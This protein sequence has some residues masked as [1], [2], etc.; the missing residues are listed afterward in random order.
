MFFKNEKYLDGKD[1]LINAMKIVLQVSEFADDRD[2]QYKYVLDCDSPRCIVL[3]ENIDFLKKPTLPRKHNIELW[4]AGGKNI[5][6]LQYADTRGLP[7]FYSCDWDHDGLL[8]YTLVKHKLLDIELLLPTGP[9]KSISATE[10]DSHWKNK[11]QPESLSDLP[12]DLFDDPSKRLIVE[13]ISSDTWVIEE[14]ND[15]LSMLST[16]G[17]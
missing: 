15:L 10:H 13:L 2:Q 14:S 1:S 12:K 9:H 11:H 8:I 5:A 7:I 17:I 6:K 4:Y 16:R 3:C